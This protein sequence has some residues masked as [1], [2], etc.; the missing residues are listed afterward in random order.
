MSV[1][2]TSCKKLLVKKKIIAIGNPAF[3]VFTLVGLDIFH[4]EGGTSGFWQVLIAM[5]APRAQ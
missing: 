2:L 5:L 1:S 3:P 4:Y